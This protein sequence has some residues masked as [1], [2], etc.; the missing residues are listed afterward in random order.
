MPPPVESPRGGAP[1]LTQAR[2]LSDRECLP[3]G[4]QILLWFSLNLLL[5]CLVGSALFLSDLGSSFRS[6]DPGYAKSELRNSFLISAIALTS[7]VLFWI[8]LFRRITRPIRRMQRAAKA[9]EQGNF[10][11]RVPVERRD[12]LGSL[13]ASLN[14]LA[15]QLE[16]VLSSKQQ[17]LADIA[18]ELSSPVARME[19]AVSILESK[20]LPEFKAD[21]HDIREEVSQM[22]G[23]L[24]ELLH[25]S[26]G[27]THPTSHLENVSVACVIHSAL[28]QEAVPEDHV[29]TTG[30]SPLP[31][32]AAPHL[33]KRAIANIVRN[34]QRYAAGG[35]PLRIETRQSSRGVTLSLT[36]DGPGVD[37]EDIPKLCEP[38]FRPESARS[39]RTG[40]VGL[41]LSI[42]KRCVEACSGTLVISNAQ[43]RG[44]CVEITLQP[45]QTVTT[46][47]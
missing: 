39:R 35:A 11:V 40:G 2:S 38:F 18:H 3:I 23:L 22:S 20:A 21:L 44:L 37:A 1:G 28:R 17:F 9:L 14:E 19:W 29:D 47:A 7:S 8:P 26:K 45:G 10:H 33:L 4:L 30:V 32:L 46:P 12:E 43:P 5:L 16:G 42:V 36:D 25:F 24:Q 6:G 31:V 15:S 41:G 27:K 13:A 34:A